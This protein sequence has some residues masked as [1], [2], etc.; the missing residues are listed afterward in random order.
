MNKKYFPR[1]SFPPL[2]LE[3]AFLVCLLSRKRERIE[4]RGFTTGESW[5]GGAKR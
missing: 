2:E 4:V 3:I 1:L 5:I